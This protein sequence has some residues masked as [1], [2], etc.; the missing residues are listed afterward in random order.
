[1][2]RMGAGKAD[3]QTGVTRLKKLILEERGFKSLR[4][5]SEK[6][7]IYPKSRLMA[8]AGGGRV[9]EDTLKKMS[10]TLGVSK[11]DLIK[12]GLTVTEGSPKKEP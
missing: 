10:D 9:S 4:A 8:A 1:M 3:L 7:G 5:F 2:P 12:M 6:A 11:E